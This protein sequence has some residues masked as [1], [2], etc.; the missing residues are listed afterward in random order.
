MTAELA[1]IGAGAMGGAIGARF[2]ATGHLLRVF[3]PDSARVAK[4]TA[5]GA[6]AAGSAA[7]AARQAQAV[8]LSLNSA[9]I[10][11][12]AVFG[13]A[14]VAEGAAAGTLIIDMSSID[15]A[16]TRDLAQRAAEAGLA[17]VD[18]PLSGGAPKAATGELTLML[19]G[20][21]ADV[22]RARLVLAAVAANITHMGP[23]GAG[24]ATKLINQVLCGLNF[25][26]VAEATALAEAAGI[27]AER[28]PLALRG[29]RADSA[30]L[31]E[32]MPRFATRDYRRTG[33]ID[34]MV[35]DLDGALAV[36]RA[37]TTAMPLTAVCAEVHRGLTA[38]GLGGE[39]QAALME[40]FRPRLTLENN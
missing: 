35:K 17:W 27:A 19:G 1:L 36:A 15:P 3:D 25:L 24:Q 32:Y 4:L 40:Y 11:E 37:T 18:A 10:A 7:E 30:I 2:R 20:A 12:A 9:R 39:D 34:N 28:I 23:A 8:I 6:V 31:Q 22:D 5:Q 13:P 33:R 16:A 29:G 38:A 26:A 21:D 14:G